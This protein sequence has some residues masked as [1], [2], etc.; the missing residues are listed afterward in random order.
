[1]DG[2]VQ[3]T[4]PREDRRRRGGRVVVG[5][6]IPLGIVVSGAIVW[7][8]SYAAFTATTESKENSWETGTVILTNSQ[9]DDSVSALFDEKVLTPGQSGSKC[10]TV[11][12][13][14]SVAAEV[15]MTGEIEDALAA[16]MTLE[17]LR[18][19]G[20]SG[21]GNCGS[22]AQDPDD[23]VVYY[24]LAGGLEA[25]LGA[26]PEKWLGTAGT[27]ESPTTAYTYKI[28]W[29]IPESH[30]EQGLTAKGHFTWTATSIAPPS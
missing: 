28:T 25:G 16:V 30:D 23:P 11:T 22:F 24:G 6:A 29:E 8:A 5:L 17:I 9:D 10:I 19:T 20:N 15:V 3:G 26:D 7:Q 13:S 18:G 1:M 2:Q 27:P 14:G 12:Y 4:D 21:D